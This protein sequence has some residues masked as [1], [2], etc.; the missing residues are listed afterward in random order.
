MTNWTK[1][2]RMIVKKKLLVILLPVVFVLLASYVSLG[3]IKPQYQASTQLIV[4]INSKD[5]TSG[6]T[7]ED[8]LAAQLL[9]KNYQEL[10]KSRS[11]TSEVIRNLRLSGMTDDDFANSVDVV[12]V[13]DSSMIRIS[14]KNESQAEAVN[15][16]D[17]ASRV[18]IEKASL[19]FKPD[20]IILI[21]KAVASLKPV[22][23]RTTLILAFSFLAGIFLSLGLILVM[24][25]F[26]DTL[27][28]SAE[29]E[30]RTGL[31]VVGIIPDM[32]IR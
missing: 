13:P 19:L 24:L 16:A 9:V 10:I 7:Y 5:N 31:P 25:F 30:K 23:P 18:F 27:G 26:D 29:I 32:N 20:N 12:L 2:L 17:E 4:L 22:Y 14:V 8:L 3:L 21:D 1:Y 11:V 28:D 6:H 15:M